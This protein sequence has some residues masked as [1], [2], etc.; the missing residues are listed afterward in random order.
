MSDNESTGSKK[1]NDASDEAADEKREWK[2]TV[3]ENDGK[4]KYGTCERDLKGYGAV[5]VTPNW[6]RSAK[7]ALNFVINY[8]E[9]G[10]MCLLHGDET[11]ESLL[12]DLGPNAQSYR[13]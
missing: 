8:E 3:H 9:G 13:K 1:S 12:S 2:H 5:P 10:E 11:S 4:S 6:P 7:V